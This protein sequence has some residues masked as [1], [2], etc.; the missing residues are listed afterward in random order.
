M[1]EALTLGIDFMFQEMAL[2]RIMANYMPRNERS[3]R[4]LQRLGFAIEGQ[5][6]DYLMINGRWEDHT[7][8]SLIN[9]K[10]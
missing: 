4:V 7:L 2:H 5:A 8:T 6:K 1:H 3:A 10:I 9:S